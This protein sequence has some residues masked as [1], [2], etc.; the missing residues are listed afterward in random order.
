[1][2][3]LCFS[4][5]DFREAMTDQRERL[6]A[7]LAGRYRVDRQLGAGGMATVYLAHDVRHNRGVA[8]KVLRPEL[9]AIVG[10]DRFLSEIRTTANLQHPHILALFDSGDVNGTVFYVMPYIEGESLR[11]RLLRERQLPIDDA[12]RITREVAS[13]LDYAHR[14]GVIHRDIKPENI[15]LHDG[16]ALVADFGIALAASGSSSSRMTET[17]I[18]L[19]TP[20]YMSP[21]QATGDRHL[22]ARSDVYALGCVLYEMLSGEPPFTGPTA[23][24]IATKVLTD[25]AKPLT[26]LRRTVPVHVAKA[27]RRALQKLP[28][29]RF[30]SARDFADALVRDETPAASPEPPRAGR[31]A[32]TVR[33]AAPLIVVAALSGVTGWYLSQRATS[34]DSGPSI[35]SRLALLAPSLGGAGTGQLHRQ[36]T[37][38]ADGST[39]YYLA[40]AGSRRSGVLAHRLDAEQPT[41]IEGTELKYAPSVSPDGRWLAA[42]DEIGDLNR[43]ALR[44]GPNRMVTEI[45]RGYAFYAWHPDGSLW[46][47]RTP[48]RTLERLPADSDTIETRLT[49]I[50]P[51][52]RPQQILDD[53]RTAIVVV[54]TSGSSSGPCALMDLESGRRTVLIETAVTA[55]RYTAG[56]LVYALPDGTLQTSRLDLAGKRLL[57]RPV[58]LATGVGITAAGD[59]QFD[60]SRNGTVAYAPE[61]PRSLV[62]VDRSGTE[63]LATDEHQNFHMPRFSPDGRRLSV[64]FASAGGRDVW[65]LDLQQ[66]TLTRTTFD[67]DGHDATWAPDGKSLIYTSNRTGDFGI[68]KTLPGTGS[69]AESLVV[70]SSLGYTGDWLRDGSGLLTVAINLQGSSAQDLAI[71]RNHGKGPIEP[72]I[73][74]PFREYFPA[75]SSDGRWIAFVSDQSGRSEVYVRTL[76]SAGTMT[77]VS[78]GG[79]DEPLWS[80]DGRDLFYRSYLPGDVKLVA[81]RVE[82]TPAFRVID[83]QALFSVAAYVNSTPHTGYEVSPD[84]TYFV[85]VRRNPASRIVI[86]QNLPELARRQDGGE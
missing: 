3:K 56:H 4:R 58:V 8:L 42:R 62:F 31:L 48:Y 40:A 44:T 6:T 85:F 57:A 54:A 24:A 37:L 29:D 70:S 82:T 64:D 1:M 50:S 23:Q 49:D 10:A 5:I 69:P 76:D 17:G 15:L 11:D 18:S 84:G 67:K 75:L 38:S 21:E 61:A 9:A 12:I 68:F 63:R 32:R 34:R 51:G 22:D 39:L 83:R 86:I 33:I 26:E 81:A 41:P 65:I 52:V 53:G 7:A 60:V 2:L 13:A 47:T 45:A 77:Q 20:T 19:G 16:Q 35:P 43:I 30:A 14:R 74:T 79:G 78:Q 80:R 28:A 59:A 36:I 27:A 55:A 25:E 73:A 72:L 71:V 66:K 46:L